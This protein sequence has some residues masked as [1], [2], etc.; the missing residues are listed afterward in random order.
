MIH[1]PRLAEMTAVALR[2]HR[3]AV[4]AAAERSTDASTMLVAVSAAL[5][6][7]VPSA[8]GGWSV[9]DP[10]IILPTWPIHLVN[11]NFNQ[12][13]GYWE[14]EFSVEDRLLFRDLATRERP[15]GTLHAE[16]AGLLAR[17]SR[18]REAI[19]SLGYG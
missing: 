6:R 1:S 4:I 8:A 5:S 2:R 16:T 11:V 7:F 9:T 19:S 12:G 17:S 10:G 14:R 13:V 15:L 18:Y 3:A